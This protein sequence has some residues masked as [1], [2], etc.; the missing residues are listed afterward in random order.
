MTNQLNTRIELMRWLYAEPEKNVAK[1]C[2]D[3]KHRISASGHLEYYAGDWKFSES[4][5]NIEFPFTKLEPEK[6]EE[7]FAKIF[8]DRG[9]T[10]DS[11][12]TMVEVMS[13]MIEANNRRGK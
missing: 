6:S 1:S 5:S 3:I 11:A 8:I 13:G 9:W 12:K 7:D 2:L 4:I 10:K